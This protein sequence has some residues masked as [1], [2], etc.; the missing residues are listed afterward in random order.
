MPSNQPI[1]MDHLNEVTDNDKAFQQELFQLFSETAE[2]CI[3]ALQT[4]ASNDNTKE[5]RERAHELKGSSANMGANALA[6]ICKQA[7]D[8]E[9]A[10]QEQKK[11]M[12]AS[13]LVEYASVK[14]FFR[15]YL[16]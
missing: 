7:M 5:W 16:A 10:T 9:N 15:Q 11:A 6:A 1:D 4:L 8:A 14:E 3:Q 2:K 12:F 13:I